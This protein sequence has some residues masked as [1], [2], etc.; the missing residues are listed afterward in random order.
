MWGAHSWNPMAYHPQL[1]LVYIPVIDVPTVVTGYDNGDFVDTLE[2]LTEVD[3]RPF[4][5]G[6][7]VAWDPVANRPR[8][9]VD[10]DLP[11]NGGVLATAGNLVF[12]G[13]AFG[14]FSAY[15]ADSGEKLWSVATG[16]NITAAPV[17][18]S[19]NGKQY[20]LVPVGA[21]GGVQFVYPQMHAGKQIHGPT[22]LMAFALN[23][24]TPIPSLRAE[25]RPLPPQ[26]ELDASPEE[27]ERGRE[28]FSRECKGCHGN[29]AVARFGG[30]VPDLRYA[31]A[32]THAAWHGI[33]VGGALQMNGM[34]RF[35]LGIEDSEAVRKYVLSQSLSISE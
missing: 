9:T 17:S 33:V 4:S 31:T 14:R 10:H 22:R 13:D 20:V 27:L 8:W 7:L 23:E 6:K 2:M 15:A 21:G 18:Y 34:P 19:L 12:Q 3:G 29:N 28:V 30:S 35:E 26:P 1:E 5:P 25:S 11:F 16:S 24:K 32:D